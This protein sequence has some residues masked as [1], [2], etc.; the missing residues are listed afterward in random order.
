MRVTIMFLTKF[1]FIKR[2][3]V[4]FEFYSFLFDAEQNATL[5]FL[6]LPSHGAF[7]V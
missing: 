7:Q 2:N 1:L 3:Y 6:D 4:I 5:F